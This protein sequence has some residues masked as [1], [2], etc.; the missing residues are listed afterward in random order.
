MVTLKSK[1][2]LEIM[3]RANQLVARILSDLRAMARPGLRTIELDQFAE[4][5][6][7]REGARPAFKGYRGYPSTLC[8]SVNEEIV[9]G[10]PG[11]RVLQDGDLVSMDLG[12]VLD[13]FIGDA[14]ITVPVGAISDKASKQ[15]RVTE[16]ALFF[17]IEK[18]RVGGRLYDISSAIQWHA[19]KNGY[20]VVRVF[21]GHGVGRQLHEE[22][23]VPNFGRRGRGMPLKAGM[24]LAIE[25]MVNEGTHEVRI[26]SD[27]W[28]AV[29]LDGKLSVHCEHSVAI[30][31]EG[32]WI[33][34]ELSA[35]EASVSQDMQQQT[36]RG[37]HV[38]NIHA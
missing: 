14:A 3:Y 10:I 8:I 30:T 6:V 11:K 17:G 12:V 9:H 35:T 33:L 2:E 34:S 13:G 21:V 26:L 29:T 36:A 22:P 31:E 4:A 1:A 5:E 38:G 28:T 20:S 23:Q 16:E 25:P 32:P 18:A 24:V 15:L 7:V 37:L 19:E 27:N